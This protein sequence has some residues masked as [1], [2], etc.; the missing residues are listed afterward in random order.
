MGSVIG[1]TVLFY[2]AI[3][4]EV[5]HIIGWFSSDYSSFKVF[6]PLIS[7]YAIALEL[8]WLRSDFLRFFV[9]NH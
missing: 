8:I 6:Y 9:Y 4:K 3:S 7:P 1:H 5:R 2:G